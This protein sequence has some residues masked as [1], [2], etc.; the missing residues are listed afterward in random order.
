M[1]ENNNL[2]LNVTVNP[3]DILK[4]KGSKFD[5]KTGE[6]GYFGA[7]GFGESKYD[8]P[9]ETSWADIESGNLNELRAQRQPSL[10]K[11]GSGLANAVTQ[12]S[13]IHI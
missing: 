11:I 5:L 1:P 12:L 9:Q 10:A 3:E 6:K 8:L 13:L 7:S 4:S 2:N